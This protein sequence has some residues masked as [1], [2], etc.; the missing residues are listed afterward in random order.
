MKKIT[1]MM[2][3]WA[4]S[5]AVVAQDTVSSHLSKSSSEFHT[6]FGNGKGGCKIPLGYFF[7]LNAGY[8]Q[9]GNQDVFLPGMSMGLILDHHWTIGATGSFIGN[10]Y[11]LHFNDIYYDSTITGL[12]GAYLHGGYGGLLLEYTLMPASRVHVVFPLMIGGGYMYYSNQTTHYDSAYSHHTNHGWHNHSISSDYFF[13]IEP[14]V[15]VEF[16]VIKPLRI[17]LGVSYRYVPDLDLMNTSSGLLNQFTAKLTVRF[18][19]F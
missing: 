6:L 4:F 10:L 3:C 9:F 5:L 14:G 16:N 8:T 11:G 2:I 1:V 13:A 15:R 17:G 7:E 12:H 19:K 18:G